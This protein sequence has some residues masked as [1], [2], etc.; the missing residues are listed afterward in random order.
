MEV[1]MRR[2]TRSVVP[3]A[4]LLVLLLSPGARPRQAPS[5]T[6][7]EEVLGESAHDA[8][9][10]GRGPRSSPDARR[11]AWTEKRGKK[12]VALVN[13]RQL[14]TEYEEPLSPFFSPNS[15]H[16]AY[17]ARRNQKGVMVLDGKEVGPECDQIADGT[18]H[19]DSERVAYFCQR[20]KQWNLI[21][22]EAEG[23]PLDDLKIWLSSPHPGIVFSPDGKRAAYAGIREKRFVVLLDGEEVASGYDYA[24]APLFSADS[25]HFLFVGVK[26]ETSLSK[27]TLGIPPRAAGT[28]VL[29]GRE[30]AIYRSQELASRAWGL[31]PTTYQV[32]TP[33]AIQTHLAGVNPPQFLPDGKLV[34]AARRGENDVVVMRGDEVGPQHVNVVNGPAVSPD[35]KRIAYFTLA[36]GSLVEVVDGKPG[37]EYPARTLT[38]VSFVGDIVFSP[39]GTRLAYEFGR[40]GARPAWQVLFRALRR[41]VLDGEEGKE[42]DALAL[43]NLTFSPASRRFAYE[44]HDAG[45]QL[46]SLIVLDGL[47]GKSYEAVFSNSLRFTDEDTVVYVAREGRRYLRVTQSLR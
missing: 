47:E 32:V 21:L 10:S 17:V 7:E 23:P 41:V 20:N 1:G 8:W 5:L 9:K 11:V 18:F 6:L 37:R 42:Y 16:V 12:W 13:G 34:Y 2:T 27:Q 44:V 4:F 43:T 19:P 3:V 46:R 31:S 22:G 26:V 24:G 33:A 35:G 14:G 36:R 30:I 45:R 39:D 40:H 28:I 15:Q 38:R 25:Q 29:D